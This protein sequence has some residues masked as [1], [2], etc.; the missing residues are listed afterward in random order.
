MSD[1]D[2]RRRSM[3]ELIERYRIR[4]RTRQFLESSSVASIK[5]AVGD[6]ASSDD[7]SSPA[8]AYVE[9]KVQL[10]TESLVS[11]QVA[12]TGPS[13][14]YDSGGGG[15]VP[16]FNPDEVS[17][18]SGI[19]QNPPVVHTLFAVAEEFFRF[20]FESSDSNAVLQVGSETVSVGSSLF[21]EAQSIGPLGLVPTG[22]VD[23]S[24]EIMISRWK[25]EP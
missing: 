17:T 16:D 18:I 7:A 12:E 19:F 15:T 24:Y 3:A 2:V 23:E 5:R 20:D 13:P 11:G 14:D 9:K 6:E 21:L 22:Q 4:E 10:V 1:V 25:P 8:G